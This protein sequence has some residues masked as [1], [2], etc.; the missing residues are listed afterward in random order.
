MSAALH[1]LEGARTGAEYLLF[2]LLLFV[3]WENLEDNL[4]FCGGVEKEKEKEGTVP[5][6]RRE[7]EAICV[8]TLISPKQEA[9]SSIPRGKMHQQEGESGRGEER[10]VGK[11]WTADNRICSKHRHPPEAP[12]R[13]GSLLVKKVVGINKEREKCFH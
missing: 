12:S 8:V 13:L 11:R 4:C 3:F 1:L 5:V 10:D 2:L 6:K 9:G 7:A